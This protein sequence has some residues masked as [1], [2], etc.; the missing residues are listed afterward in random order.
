MISSPTAGASTTASA[1]LGRAA[2][3]GPDAPDAALATAT[4]DGAPDASPDVVVTLSGGRPPVSSTYDATGRVPGGPS[5]NDMGANGPKSLAKATEAIA[6]PDDGDAPDPAD[7]P[8][9][10]DAVPA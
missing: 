4:D 10:E 9:P 1:A 5:L 6:A 2:P 8:S 3:A 7:A